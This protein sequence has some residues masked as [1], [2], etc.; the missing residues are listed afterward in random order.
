MYAAGSL[1][2]VEYP[3]EEVC[4]DLVLKIATDGACSHVFPCSVMLEL[5]VMQGGKRFFLHSYGKI[6]LHSHHTSAA[7]V[8]PL[9]ELK[10]NKQMVV[11]IDA[12]NH[13]L[14][15]LT[16]VKSLIALL[17]SLSLLFSPPPPPPPP[18]PLLSSF[19]PMILTFY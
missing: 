17:C 14:L 8:F 19:A 12:I 6:L 13:T 4:L 10:T 18:H 2:V 11:F 15:T 9:K 1:V 7:Y 16:S 5:C 3:S